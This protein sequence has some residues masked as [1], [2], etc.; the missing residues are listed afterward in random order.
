[1][2]GLVT[3]LLLGVGIGFLLAPQSGEETRRQLREQWQG[4][5]KNELVKQYLPSLVGDFSQVR[6]GLGDLAQFAFQ[7]MKANETS[8]NDLAQLAVDKM[9]SYRISL[10]DLSGFA[11]MMRKKAS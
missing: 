9:M 6:S 2:K 1:M 4:L 5:K 8:L 7:Q 11:T 10:N 3:G